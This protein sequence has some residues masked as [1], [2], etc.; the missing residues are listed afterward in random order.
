LIE[1]EP[2]PKLARLARECVV[3]EKL[4]GTNAQVKIIDP[5]ATE[6]QTYED[7][8]QS[9][10]ISVINGLFIFAQTIMDLL[11]GCETTPS[12]SFS[13][14]KDGTSE[15]GME[16][17]SNE[18]TVS[19]SAVSRCLT[20]VD[21]SQVPPQLLKSLMDEFERQIASA[22][23][24]SCIEGSSTLELSSTNSGSLQLQAHAPY[25]GS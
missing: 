10:P 11:R 18:T 9:E 20:P 23:Y 15:N 21:T 17:A 6:G 24:Q 4:D 1:F 25:L 12:S 19:W 2:F 5:E 7:I 8:V 14:A 3:T 16:K 13:W 22:L